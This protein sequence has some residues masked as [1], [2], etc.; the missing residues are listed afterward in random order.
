MTNAW[1]ELMCCWSISNPSAYFSLVFGCSLLIRSIL[2]WIKAYETKAVFHH[3][4]MGHLAFN[5]FMGIN[6]RR[7]ERPDY[8]FLYALGVCELACYPVLMATQNFGVICVWIGFKTCLQWEG[9]KRSPFYVYTYLV[10]NTT[11]LSISIL[12]MNQFVVI[13]Y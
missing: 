10:G 11:V 12:L 9:W 8:W 13:A 6:P 3:E 5:T 2:S 7:I 1:L 4:M